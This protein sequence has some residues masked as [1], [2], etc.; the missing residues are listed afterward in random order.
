[1]PAFEDV[2]VLSTAAKPK[3]SYEAHPA[4]KELGLEGK[5][6]VDWSDPELRKKAEAFLRSQNWPSV[7]IQSPAEPVK[8]PPHVQLQHD[9]PAQDFESLSLAL[10]RFLE[11][12]R[13]QRQFEALGLGH[14]VDQSWQTVL[15]EKEKNFEHVL[16]FPYNGETSKEHLLLEHLTPVPRWF[17]R[18]HGEIPRIQPE[19]YRLKVTGLVKNPRTFTLDELKSMDLMEKTVTLQCSG[20]RRIEQIRYALGDGDSLIN[21]PWHEQAI[22][23]AKWKG[24]SL[25]KIL[26]ACGGVTEGA[27]DVEFVSPMPSRPRP[28]FNNN[29]VA[30]TRLARADTYFKQHEVDNYK[31]SVGMKKV[32]ANEVIVAWEQNGEPLTWIHGAP[33]RTVVLG[34]IGARSC[35][36]LIEIRVLPEVSEGPV[37]RKEYLL[38][39]HQLSKYNSTFADGFSIQD[40]PVSSA[41]MSPRE[42]EVVVHDGTVKFKGW[43]Y[44]GGGCFV[45]RVEVSVDGGHSWWPS[46]QLTEKSYYGWRLWEVDAPIAAEGWLEIVCRAWDSSCN[47]QPSLVRSAWNWGLHVTSHACRIKIFSVNKSNPVT[48]ARLKFMEEN[49]IPLEPLTEPL[50]HETITAAELAKALRDNQ[51]EPR[52]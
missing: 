20:G 36:W 47:T 1:M 43:A 3:L 23:N 10:P 19:D 46:H 11:G 14:L 12:Y 4:A 40:M 48:A 49:N 26:K 7:S 21:A 9:F 25:K 45:Q 38:L 51:R 37:Q 13:W 42:G 34:V 41:I 33:V 24:V 28:S 8:G 18:N 15:E 30:S 5:P 27:T 39:N 16:R 17:V 2:D 50:E 31:V 32:K 44:S 35:K 22:S 6:W 52:E 29:H